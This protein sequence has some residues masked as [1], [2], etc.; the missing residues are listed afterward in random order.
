VSLRLIEIA[1]S[2]VACLEGSRQDDNHHGTT[3]WLATHHFR[4]GQHLKFEH[5]AQMESSNKFGA[6]WSRWAH[7]MPKKTDTHRPHRK[8]KVAS[9]SRP[10]LR[11]NLDETQ[12][13]HMELTVYVF[14]AEI[15]LYI[16]MESRCICVKR[17]AHSL[18]SAAVPLSVSINGNGCVRALIDLSLTGPVPMWMIPNSAMESEITLWK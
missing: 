2:G 6:M 16:K 10:M 8:Y 4:W 3:F 5:N 17:M 12:K 18:E 11:P 1:P 13:R 9:E 7:A 14:M 15:M